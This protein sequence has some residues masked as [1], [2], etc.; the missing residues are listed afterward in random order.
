LPDGNLEFIDR[1]DNQVKIRG[2]RIELG[3]I[4]TVLNKSGYV[5]N[6]VVVAPVRLDGNKLLVAYII[7]KGVF[8]KKSIQD[9]L[10][11][12]LP[13]YLIPLLVVIDN[14][15]YTPNGKIDKKSLPPPD[16]FDI[17]ANES[18]EPG[19]DTE[20]A[21]AGI[22]KDVL[23]IKKI[24]ILDDFFELGGHSLLAT[25][26][27]ARIKEKFSVQLT[28]AMLFEY[29]TIKLLSEEILREKWE[30]PKESILIPINPKGTQLP[31]FCAPPAGGNI[32]L[33]HELSR[34]LG[35]DQ[36]IYAFQSHGMD[37]VSSPFTSIEEM[38]ADYIIRMQK[39]D[40][41]G[42]YILAGY[43]FGGKVIYEMA[44]Q[45]INSGFEVSKLIIFDTIA[46]DKH[47]T[48]YQEMLP[49][50]FVDWLLFFK[51]IYNLSIEE[52]HLKLKISADQ[53]LNK[54]ADEQ[55][56][57]FYDKLIEKGETFT[58][59]QLR[60]YTKVYMINAAI[61]YVPGEGAPVNVFTILF[62]AQELLTAFSAEQ[63][64]KEN[65]LLEG[66][67]NKEDLG[68]RDFITNDVKIHTI[69]CNHLNMMKGPNIKIIADHLK[70]YLF[71]K[72]T[73]L[74]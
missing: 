35:E 40:P 37:L 32:M 39:I 29:P 7:P 34:A 6:S 68:W 45:L 16:F 41:A 17:K 19:N 2:Y 8:D 50:T 14:F 60:A 49:A 12:A 51:D 1:K 61:S 20:A 15:P 26:L 42:P 18:V 52:D 27:M 74:L 11:S 64:E 9:C 22:W 38:A 56:E 25:R 73:D 47:R 67:A 72:N 3:E 5:E 53:F 66:R 65:E 48:N 28:I 59:E 69:D 4:E 30:P 13:N 10:K 33:Y 54:S 43:S 21:L 55:L 70:V 71:K 23:Q 57:L 63:I 31:V 36:P 62:K 46:P 58:I 44:I 24:G